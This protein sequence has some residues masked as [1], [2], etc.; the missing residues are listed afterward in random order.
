[1]THFKTQ[2]RLPFFQ[3]G[4]GFKVNYMLFIQELLAHTFIGLRP[5]L[6]LKICGFEGA[7]LLKQKVQ[8]DFDLKKAALSTFTPIFKA[9]GP[10][11]A[12]AS[13]Y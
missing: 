4:V 2:K 9:S 12:S 6:A 5:F 10:M 3:N 1:L 8:T 11:N 13:S 7:K